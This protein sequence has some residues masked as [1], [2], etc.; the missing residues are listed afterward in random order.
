MRLQEGGATAILFRSI[1]RFVLDFRDY[2]AA[3]QR[4]KCFGDQKLRAK[5]LPVSHRRVR[6]RP[7]PL[8]IVVSIFELTDIGVTNTFAPATDGV[9]FF[10]L[11]AIPLPEF[12]QDFR[13]KNKKFSF[14]SC[15]NG[16]PRVPLALY[17]GVDLADTCG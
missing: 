9:G 11:G 16:T 5:R 6:A 12:D 13:A 4:I 3:T 2:S 7:H 8:D 14:G 1:H 15:F 17:P 10:D